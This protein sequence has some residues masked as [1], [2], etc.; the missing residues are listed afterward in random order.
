MKKNTQL[1]KR[2][3]PFIQ[4][5]LLSLL[6]TFGFS[7]A[8]AQNVQV[9]G[10]V[11]NANNEPLPGVTIVQE[12]TTHGALTDADGSYLLKDV[13][14]EASLQ[15]TMVGM[16]TKV[17]KVD[18]R[19]R[20]D[21]SM[22]PSSVNLRQYV[23]VG[24]GSMRKNDVTGSVA[25][26]SRDQ[27]QSNPYMNPIQSIQG[28]VAGVDIYATSQEPGDAPS[29]RV[30]GNRSI[31]A[32]N[33]PLY[34]VD[35]IP[36]VGNLKDIN[37][38]DI[39]SME[40]LKDASATAIYGS[41]G[42]NGVILVTT[43]RGKAGNIAVSYDG[44][45]GTQSNY[46]LNMMNAEQFVAFRR[47]ARR[48]AGKYPSDVPNL[49]LDKNMFYYS[50]KYVIES[51]SAAYDDQGNYDPSK[52]KSYDWTGAITRP[53]LIEDH[54][55]NI[56]GGGEN[57][58]MS[59]SVGYFNNK[60][61]TKGFDYNKYSMRLT[62]DQKV[63][64]WLKI[65]GTM[66]ASINT[67][68]ESSN[69]N[70]L[71]Y[72]TNPLNPFRDENGILQMAPGGEIH[73]NPILA[74]QNDII[75]HKANRY[76]GSFYVEA[77]LIRGLK[78]RMNFGPD[79]QDGRNGAF[80]GSLGTRLGADPTASQSTFRQFHYT[81][82]NL[83]YY[84]KVLNDVHR[85]S[86]TGLYSVEQYEYENLNGSV[87]GLPYEY[88][89]WFNLGTATAITGIGS[90]YQRWR[91]TSYMARANY[92]FK[93]KYVLTLTGRVDG[94]SRLA[95]GHK[96]SFFPSAAVA[97]RII[98]EPFLKNNNIFDNLK[99]RLGYG[100]TG[101]TSI[102]P[103]ETL[104]SLS[105]T[106]YSTGD[107]A[108][109]GYAPGLL[110][111]PDL[112]WERTGQVDAGLDFSVLAN[113]LTGTIDVYQQNTTDLLLPRQ[114]PIASGFSSITQN[115]G[116]TRNTGIE[117]SLSAQ[118]IKSTRGFQWQMDVVFSSNKEE[119]VSL[120]HGKVDDIGNKWF[121]GKPI[122]T[123][124]DYKFDGIWQS[125][126][127]DKSAMAQYNS[128]GSNYAPGEIKVYDKNKDNKITADDRMILG[129]TV[130]KWSGSIN[131]SFSYKG[132]DFSI[133]IYTRQGQMV[134]NTMNVQYEGRYNWLNVD[135]WT[136]TNP[137][138]SWPRPVDGRMT[139]LNYQTLFYQ[140]GSFW[141][142]KTITLGYTLPQKILSKIKMTK[143]RVYVTAQN[144][145]MNTP[146][147]GIDPEG[148][149]G[150]SMPSVKTFL[151]GLSASF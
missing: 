126:E 24:Y 61:T 2:S 25:S 124:Y 145:Y 10:K 56:T 87:E 106:T 60:G 33:D 17:I 12:G 97:W 41:R 46:H 81:W 11:T 8:E 139:P 65:G 104:G 94:S 9:T 93:D 99:L 82:D 110:Y 129:S 114:L 80:Y 15:F 138:N 52:I 92:S 50:D 42:A 49:E 125:T 96:F 115:I 121:I 101:N 53:G 58:Q 44:Y 85:I 27:I 98:E 40:I 83:I 72:Q 31:Q 127:D 135:Y 71:A 105:R 89:H 118:L 78:Y 48:N 141:K 36:F 90:S 16:E 117:A 151:I 18:G 123:Y 6:L 63:R 88:Q 67:K 21:V 119:I 86:L 35:G 5:T 7:S 13:P 29:I 130:P 149:T 77:T 147:I 108:F 95:E 100:M 128:N 22:S 148:A 132:F 116:S 66:A 54:E 64:E 47:E 57:T 73:A 120:Y 26:V 131:N 38:A 19:S 69:I 146:F 102:D 39:E 20:I 140:D 112:R 1:L 28:K 34:V 143:L 79:F 14:I 136:P 91:L 37:S 62:I 45:Y 109:L 75:N 111:N 59:F 68:N 70:L 113:R 150:L 3:N 142:I 76:Y 55:L 133:Y 84:D 74:A 103:Y 32:S 134:Y 23:A 43:R 4:W 30:R 51:I 144:P 122:S 107:E 137:S